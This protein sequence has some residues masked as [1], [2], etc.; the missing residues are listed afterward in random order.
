MWFIK[1]Q[2]LVKQKKIKLRNKWHFVGNK[3]DFAACLK[4]AVNFFAT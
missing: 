3:T 4:S 1:K 2:V